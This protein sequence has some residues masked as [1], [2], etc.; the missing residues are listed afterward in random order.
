[1]LRYRCHS[2]EW[3]QAVLRGELVT[4]KFIKFYLQQQKI[5]GAFF[6]NEP[7]EV[8][9]VKKL[10]KS[11]FVINELELADTLNIFNAMKEASVKD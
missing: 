7:K 8:A 4:D 11:D 2:L 6:V 9:V 3:D 5:V 10:M 1:M